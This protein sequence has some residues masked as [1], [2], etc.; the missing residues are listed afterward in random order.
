[1]RSKNDDLQPHSQLYYSTETNK[2]LTNKRIK[3][4]ADELEKSDKE[5]VN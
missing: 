3:K 4:K 1:V 2:K 5:C